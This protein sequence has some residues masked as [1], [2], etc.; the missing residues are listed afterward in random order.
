MMWAYMLKENSNAFKE[1]K[2]YKALV[3]NE[4]GCKLKVLR[5]DRGG[6]EFLSNAFNAFYANEGVQRHL[7]APYMP[8]QNGVVERRNRTVVAMVRSMLKSMHMP[9]SFWREAGRHAVYILNHM[10]TKSLPTSTPY[11]AWTGKKPCLDYLK[12]FGCMAHIKVPSVQARKLDDWSS[13]IV[14]LGTKTRSKAHRLMIHVATKF[15]LV[16]M[17][18]LRKTKARTGVKL[19]QVTTS[20]GTHSPSRN[21]MMRMPQ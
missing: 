18:S 19:L 21:E 8:Q 7:T 1:F 17:C 20:L 10:A 11:E 4:A 12:V 14:Y 16:V 9:R 6:G 3:E 5:T 13:S 15:A 2:K